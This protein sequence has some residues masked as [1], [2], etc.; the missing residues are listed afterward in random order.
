MN[1]PWKWRPERTEGIWRHGCAWAKPLTAAAPW[2]SLALLM[3]TFAMAQ[4]R[5]VSAPG[6]LFDLPA[7]AARDGASFFRLRPMLWFG[8]RKKKETQSRDLP[9]S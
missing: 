2:I 4:G 1:E 5:L 7:P 3:A 8:S 9:R 6:T